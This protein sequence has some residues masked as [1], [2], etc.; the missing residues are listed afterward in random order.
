M[1]F[2]GTIKAYAVVDLRVLGNYDWRL[3][4]RNTWKAEQTLLKWPHRPLRTSPKRVR[5]LRARYRTFRETYGFKPWK[6]YRG[7]ENWT[8]LPAYFKAQ[9]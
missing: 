1:D 5:L 2:T 8:E 4:V 3:S 6:Y 7:K 9:G